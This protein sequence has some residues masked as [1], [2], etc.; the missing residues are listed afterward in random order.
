MCFLTLS[1]ATLEAPICRP[2]EHISP[3]YTPYIILMA[4]VGIIMAF[5]LAKIIT[6]Y[7]TNSRLFVYVGE[8]TMQILIWHFLGLKI[9]SLIIILLNNMPISTLENV[10]CIRIEEYPF[11]YLLCS[12]F[13]VIFSLSISSVL[14][15]MQLKIKGGNSPIIKI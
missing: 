15:T 4:L 8:N 1:I 11:L 7:K 12:L 13:A 6:R 2:F 9:I 3:I 14:E 10:R 5:E